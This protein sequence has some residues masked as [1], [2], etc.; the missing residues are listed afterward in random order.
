MNCATFDIR[1]DDYLE[2]SLAQPEREELEEHLRECCRC[3]REIESLQ[4]LL[5]RCAGLTREIPPD[6]DMWPP[7]AAEIRAQGALNQTLRRISRSGISWSFPKSHLPWRTAAAIALATLALMAAVQLVRRTPASKRTQL[8]SAPKSAQPEHVAAPV[9]GKREVFP[10]SGR[11]GAAPANQTKSDSNS[12]RRA[13]EGS[14]DPA[15][16]A[17]PT[18]TANS[19]VATSKPGVSPHSQSG[20]SEYVLELRMPQWAFPLYFDIGASP[21]CN[22]EGLRQDDT[23]PA[24]GDWIKIQTSARGDAVSIQVWVLAGS[25][26]LSIVEKGSGVTMQGP[27]GDDRNPA[28]KLVGSYSIMPEQTIQVLDLRSF[29]IKPI[30]IGLVRDRPDFPT[31]LRVV[32]RTSSL[33]VV[34]I[35]ERRGGRY[36]VTLQNVSNRT[37]I[38]WMHRRHNGEG[39]SATPLPP[40]STTS[41]RETF[42]PSEKNPPEVTVNMAM[43]EDGSYEGDVDSW[44]LF[45]ARMKV[46]PKIHA[47]RMRP[48][49]AQALESWRE[50]LASEIADRLR[51]QIASPS[52]D[53]APEV[54]NEI[55]AEDP[56]V[57]QSPKSMAVVKGPSIG[58]WEKYELLDMR[59]CCERDGKIVPA[60]FKAWLTQ[61]KEMF[62]RQLAPR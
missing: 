5:S 36:R 31:P 58:G 4:A 26:G 10:Q 1:V 47:A 24:Q 61:R 38:G 14:S 46:I 21:N 51:S 39:M 32:N 43:F 29:N 33:K 2:S 50:D 40:G 41:F 3:R 11:A 15:S 57:S 22:V 20:L 48:L 45:N 44:A 42:F 60:L 27:P 62:E 53:L 28:D 13:H 12:I 17:M 37:I 52:P 9:L 18:R 7:I 54:K 8:P 35:E 30:E 55:L 34:D 23:L 19:V 16:G 56:S 25:P 49:F 6:K 59:R